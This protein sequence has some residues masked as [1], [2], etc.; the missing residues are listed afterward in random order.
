[1]SLISVKYI[2][3]SWT[4]RLRYLIIIL[5]A[6]DFFHGSSLRLG[7]VRSES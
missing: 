1:M 4:E 7:E 2:C 6:R 3:I 5:T